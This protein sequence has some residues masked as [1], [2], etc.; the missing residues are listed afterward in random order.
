GQGVRLALALER[1][2]GNVSVFETKLL[3]AAHRRACDNF[4]YVERILKFLLWQKGGFR[5]SVAGPREIA[6]Q[7]ALEYAPGGARAFDADFF[8]KIYEQ[9]K[10]IVEHVGF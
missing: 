1:D 4:R 6:E 5:V 10:F 9:P 3:P 8:A 7:L 2:G